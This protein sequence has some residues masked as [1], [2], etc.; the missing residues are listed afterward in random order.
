VTT[1]PRPETRFLLTPHTYVA[2][3]ESAV[4]LL[5]SLSDDYILV[6]PHLALAF[7]E[8]ISGA[9]DPYSPLNGEIA[10]LV[11]NLE[12]RGSITSDPDS[13]KPLEIESMFTGNL[14]VPG[15]HIAAIPK[16]RGHHV[17]NVIWGL[18]AAFY[19][20]NIRGLPGATRHLSGLRVKSRSIKRTADASELVE[21]YHRVRP[22][23]YSAKDKCLFNSL[24][25]IL[26]L[27]R[28]G[29]VPYW[30]FGVKLNPFEAHC[31]AE[32]EKYLYNDRYSRTWRFTPI[33]KI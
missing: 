6:E 10:E 1:F 24:S 8:I 28:Y 30:C 19:L 13:G 27:S 2:K 31:W 21:I 29:I 12:R 22:F 5:D 3:V 26:F 18:G 25:M 17:L 20:L 9:R 14:E 4:I 11:R 15:P 7:I 16:A 32:D 33:M 23:F